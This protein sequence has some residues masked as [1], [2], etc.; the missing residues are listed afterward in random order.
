MAGAGASHDIAAHVY[1]SPAP[2][3]QHDTA[4][5]ASGIPSS[6]PAAGAPAAPPAAVWYV[7]ASHA[8]GGTHR[9]GPHRTAMV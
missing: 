4:P 6:P 5:P 2:P 1:R 7:P 3:A 9:T 8:A